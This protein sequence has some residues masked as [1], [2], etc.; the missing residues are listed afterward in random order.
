MGER[1]REL[2]ILILGDVVCFSLALWLT[3]FVRYLEWP[4][5]ERLQAHFGPFLMLSSLWLIIF[6]IAGLYDKLSF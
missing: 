3:L 1:T 6:Y 5:M 4:P 2:F